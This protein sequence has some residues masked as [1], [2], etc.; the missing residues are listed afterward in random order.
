MT[1]RVPL[2]YYRVLMLS[3]RADEHQIEQAYRERIDLKPGER[4]WLLGVLATGCGS[5]RPD[6]PRGG[7]CAA[8]P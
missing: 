8:E 4:S 1:V 6:D 2:D 5:S 7:F 3:A